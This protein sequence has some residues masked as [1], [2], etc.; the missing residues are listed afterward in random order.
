MDEQK[1]QTEEK[2]ADAKPEQK[3]KAKAKPEQ[4]T[5]LSAKEQL[6][7]VAELAVTDAAAQKKKLAEVAAARVEGWKARG[8]EIKHYQAALTALVREMTAF[9]KGTPFEPHMAFPTVDVEIPGA[10]FKSASFKLAHGGVT[11][12]IVPNV[13]N[14]DGDPKDAE[15]GV[16]LSLTVGDGEAKAKFV[17]FDTDHFVLNAKGFEDA[18]ISAFK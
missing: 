6:H 12:A 15:L 16:D 4:K 8:V 10:P 2:P 14:T 13:E 3:A 1:P 5:E 11:F 9:V 7:E 18:L 17:A